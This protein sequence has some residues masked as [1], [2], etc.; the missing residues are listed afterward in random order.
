[1]LN[2][3]HVV[4]PVWDAEASLDFYTR[5]LGLPLVQTVSGDDWGGKRWLMMIFGLGEGRELVL[6]ALR[7]AERPPP[8]GL[9]PDVR[10]YAFAVAGETERAAWRERLADAGAS[11]WEEDHGDRLSLYV[12]DPNGVV[13]EIIAPPSNAPQIADPAA[14]AKARDWIAV[15]AAEAGAP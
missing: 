8:D 14:L 4:F 5:V 2:L 6:V 15:E 10:H 12:T 7:G 11:F 13:L 1:M 9:A 3:D